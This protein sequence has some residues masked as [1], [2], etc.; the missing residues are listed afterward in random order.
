[1]MTGTRRLVAARLMLALITFGSTL[2]LS[3]LSSASPTKQQVEAAKAQLDSL[4]QRLSLLVEQWNQA[5]IRLHE[6][7]DRLVQTKADA[8]RAQADAD[9]ALAEL[10][11]NASRAYQGFGSQVAVLFDSTS[12]A[13]FSDRLEFI[14]SLAQAESD[15]ATTAEHAQQEAAWTAEQL[16]QAIQD[17]RVVVAD[18]AAK[19][20]EIRK[21]VDEQRSIYG[22]LHRQYL[23]A[24]A[25]R[26]AA[27]EA[28]A[29]AAASGGSVVGS[30][31][32]P[33]PAPNPNA[34]AAI[35]AAYSVIGTPYVWGSADP[36]IGFDCSGL[37]MWA[38]A[39]AGVSLPHSS[40][41]QY[42]AL[43]HV[44]RTALQP[45]DLL[46]FYSPISHVAMYLTPS[47]MID[48]NHPGD[49]VNVRPINWDS[50]VAAARP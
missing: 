33:P 24:E 17:R 12:I 16:R 19:R 43:P 3:S 40:E 29:E 5:Q 9:R 10:N 36:S 14:G 8:A 18:L 39:H 42:A 30:V 48:A 23:E 7:Q 15:L 41:A 37:M 27:A 13:D 1:M 50:F 38:W 44:D 4:N 49:V 46:F 22:Q 32:G 31:P 47:T 45:G 28:A 6:V 25:A 11:Q 21:A 26:K 35:A 2:G 20:S 34:Q